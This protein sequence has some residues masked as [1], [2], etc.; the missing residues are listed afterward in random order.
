M[1]QNYEQIMTMLENHNR[2]YPLFVTLWK[3]YLSEKKKRYHSSLIQC[4]HA[5]QLLNANNI[6]NIDNCLALIGFLFQNNLL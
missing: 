6:D 5:M 4:M 2:Q 1:S 3:H